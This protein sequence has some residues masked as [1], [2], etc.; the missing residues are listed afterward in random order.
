MSSDKFH[1]QNPPT[2]SNKKTMARG[3]TIILCTHIFVPFF[4][5]FH[6]GESEFITDFFL[7]N[8]SQ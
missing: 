5:H 6:V 3:K 2:K 1:L 8:A 7:D 4:F